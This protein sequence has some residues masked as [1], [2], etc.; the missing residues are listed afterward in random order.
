M[1]QLFSSQ[2]KTY[3]TSTDLQS[4]SE[5]VTIESCLPLTLDITVDL[6]HKVCNSYNCNWKYDTLMVYL[7]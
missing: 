1:P 6:Q 7:F 3:F 2:D 4:R 5:E